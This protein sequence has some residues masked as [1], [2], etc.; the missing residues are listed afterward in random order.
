MTLDDD[1]FSTR[2]I[3][4]IDAKTKPVGALGDIEDLAFRLAR[5]QGSLEPKAETCSL[6]IFA[7]DHGMAE[8]GVSAYPQAVTR[9]MVLNFL[10]GGA[11][12]NVFARSVGAD[13]QVI[14]AG[15]AGDLIEHPGLIDRRTASGTKNAID[16]PAMT[17]A[18]AKAAVSAGIELGTTQDTDVVCFGEMGIG[19]TSAASLVAAKVLGVPVDD[20]VGR[21][22]GL[23]DD[24][25]TRKRALLNRAAARTDNKLK[26]MDAL[27]EYGG[28]EIAMIAGAM[29]SA[30]RTGRIIAVDGFIASTA[31]LC[32]RELS[33]GCE[34]NFIFAHRSAEAGHA[35]I[36]KALGAVPLLDLNMRLGEGTGALLAFPLIKAAAAMLRDM[37]SFESANVSGPVSANTGDTP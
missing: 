37:A 36:L 34:E 18:Q 29:K 27:S 28:F 5:I 10:N 4:A 21:G 17:F 9:Q 1:N 14:D 12:A 30:A 25:M 22:T 3:A 8:A 15:I 24:G 33:P 2:I 11:A 13:V 26:V 32:A 23:E 19:N 16:T 7:G 6:M 31:A 20:L 35:R